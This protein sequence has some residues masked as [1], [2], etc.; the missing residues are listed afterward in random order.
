MPSLSGCFEVPRLKHRITIR[1]ISRRLRH[2]R[3]VATAD[4][5]VPNKL[6]SSA[7]QLLRTSPNAAR[8]FSISSN[9]NLLGLCDD[10]DP[11]IVSAVYCLLIPSIS[12]LSLIELL[13]VRRFV[14]LLLSAGRS[15]GL[16]SIMSFNPC[17]HFQIHHTTHCA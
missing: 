8:Q 10:R 17:A 6:Y 14:G 13:E 7:S 9:T 1:V 16:V 4:I 11:C 12:E 15:S 5:T 2:R 3:L